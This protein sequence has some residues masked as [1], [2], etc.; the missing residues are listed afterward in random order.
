M[1]TPKRPI[2]GAK[3]YLQWILTS[4][5]YGGEWMASRPGHLISG[6]RVS[7]TNPTGGFELAPQP[8]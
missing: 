1:A 4:A 8:M 5:L 7:G 3:V 2:E 6:G